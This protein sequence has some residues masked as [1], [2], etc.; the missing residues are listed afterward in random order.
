[1]NPGVRNQIFGSLKEMEK[2]PLLGDVAKISG[3]KGLFRKRVGKYR[4]IYS[5]SFSQKR[6]SVVSILL[7][8]ILTR[9]NSSFFDLAPF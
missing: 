6:V 4:I 3:V 5:I 7:R 9:N 1:M 2:D 8:G